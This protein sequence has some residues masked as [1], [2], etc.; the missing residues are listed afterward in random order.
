LINLVADVEIA[1]LTIAD[2]P[3]EIRLARQVTFRVTD[4]A[5]ED[6]PA[7]SAIL[8]S[9]TPATV[10]DRGG[11]AAPS[12]MQAQAHVVEAPMAGTFYRSPKAGGEPLVQIGTHV[13]LGKPL[14]VIEAMKIMNEIE[15]DRAGTIKKV[16]CE[17]GQAVELGQAL[18]TIE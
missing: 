7:A 6:R 18:F 15:S 4:S 12:A 9:R 5:R 8:T 10:E 3:E 2:G 13:E 16:L 1:E 11:S 17:E 14:C